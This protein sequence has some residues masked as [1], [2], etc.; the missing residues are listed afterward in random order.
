M[1]EKKIAF[2][3]E[4][5]RRKRE[6]NTL[7]REYI[8]CTLNGLYLL[9]SHTTKLGSSHLPVTPTNE[10]YTWVTQI[11]TKIAEE[12]QVLLGQALPCLKEVIQSILVFL[13]SLHWL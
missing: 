7:D 11:V 13:V 5:K 9:R 2:S 1:E 10:G 12:K 4:I 6:K 8:P 3:E